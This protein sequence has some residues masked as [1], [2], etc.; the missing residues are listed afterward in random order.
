MKEERNLSKEAEGG[1]RWRDGAQ[2][3]ETPR[4]IFLE[5]VFS[6]LKSQSS[7]QSAV[8]KGNISGS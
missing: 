2:E 7:C 6:G 3:A 1:K 5:I 8:E 4:L